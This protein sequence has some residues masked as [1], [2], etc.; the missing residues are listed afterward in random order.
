M[1]TQPPLP[2]KVCLLAWSGWLGLLSGC[3]WAQQPP[4]V[5]TSEEVHVRGLRVTEI[6]DT[7]ALRPSEWESL[8]PRTWKAYRQ[9]T[10]DG[11][12][13]ATEWILEDHPE[14]W[15]SPLEALRWGP[16]GVSYRYRGN[17]HRAPANPETTSDAA[18]PSCFLPQ[19]LP[20]PEERVVLGAL[21][22][23][24]GTWTW[25]ENGV[26][27]VVRAFP[28]TWE[29]W[30]T[31]SSVTRWDFLAAPE[32]WFV[33]HEECRRPRTLSN[34]RCAWEWEEVTR[35][36]PV[37]YAGGNDPGVQIRVSPNPRREE[38]IYLTLL[39]DHPALA[40]SLEWV[41]V[42][43]RVAGYVAG[44]CL[45]PGWFDVPLPPGR[46][47]LRTHLGP[48]VLSQPFVQL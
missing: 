14:P 43:G 12:D 45:L 8:L 38:A 46:Y 1:I 24:V 25:E 6:G 42:H 48:Y 4:Y 16:E 10:H 36:S 33:F 7:V 34:G 2:R 18:P 28:P 22:G 19:V 30:D 21:E 37:G 23:P 11:V 44:P 26:K 27:R 31:D 41:D 20:S 29:W 3:L 32:G 47:T 17:W 39:P 9:W 15:Q 5:F 40:A 35:S 13:A